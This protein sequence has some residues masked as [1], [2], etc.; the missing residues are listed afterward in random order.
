MSQ[1]SRYIRRSRDWVRAL[2][3]SLPRLWSFEL[4]TGWPI[5]AKKPIVDDT[6]PQI[7]E[8]HNQ[9]FGLRDG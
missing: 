4:A 6:R 9:D 7:D 5:A 8:D 2:V 3:P 1:P